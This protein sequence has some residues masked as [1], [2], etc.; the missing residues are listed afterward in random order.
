M[1]VL[2]RF[3]QSF[4]RVYEQGSFDEG[5]GSIFLKSS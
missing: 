4:I 2:P 3:N 5:N 1:D